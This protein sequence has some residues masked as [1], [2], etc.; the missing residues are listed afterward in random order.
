MKVEFKNVPYKK[1]RRNAS[2]YPSHAMME[3]PD[4]RNLI[5][6]IGKYIAA[7]YTITYTYRA[8]DEPPVYGRVDCTIEGEPRNGHNS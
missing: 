2:K 8:V 3:T 4:H 5:T 7:G 6:L 1:W